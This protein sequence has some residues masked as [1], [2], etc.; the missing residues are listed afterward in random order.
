LGK[1]QRTRGSTF[2][3]EICAALSKAFGIPVQRKLGQE[4]DSGA[5]VLVGRWI[6]ECKRRRRISLYAWFDQVMRAAGESGLTPAVVT[7]A[8]DREALV[9]LKLT[10][11]IPLMRG[12]LLATT[13]KEHATQTVDERSQQA[14]TTDVYGPSTASRLG[15]V[16]S[17]VQ[18]KEEHTTGD[19][20]GGRRH[21]WKAEQD[22]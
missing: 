17:E 6:L 21:R 11:F 3:R 13:T 22:L 2:E 4:R 10:D 20:P 7:R 5:D 16:G 18:S 19:V 12:A 15:K 9:I 8:D 14:Q 1:L